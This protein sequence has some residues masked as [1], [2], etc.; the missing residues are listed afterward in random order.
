MSARPPA[1]RQLIGFA[2]H[3]HAFDDGDTSE[4]S[5]GY[6]ERLRTNVGLADGFT[7]SSLSQ[8]QTC[9]ELRKW[10]YR[11]FQCSALNHSS[12]N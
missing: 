5:C 8:S 11:S 12:T 10:R 2:G 7:G 9:C 3:V 4:A 1:V 6:V